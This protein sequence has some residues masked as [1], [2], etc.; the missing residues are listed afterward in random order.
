VKVTIF[1]GL[2]L[3]VLQVFGRLVRPASFQVSN[4]MTCKVAAPQCFQSNEFHPNDFVF[5]YAQV[6]SEKHENVNIEMTFQIIAQDG[7]SFSRE[8]NP[9]VPVP[10]KQNYSY[11]VYSHKGKIPPDMHPGIYTAQIEMHDKQ[12]GQVA[13]VGEN[14]VVRMVNR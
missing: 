2:T 9:F 3:L 14:F 4:V 6:F 5:V 12:T 1:I 13:R 8:S 7:K 11:Q 10:L